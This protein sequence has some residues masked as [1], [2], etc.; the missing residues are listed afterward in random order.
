MP[1]F[2]ILH[3]FKHPP[4][5]APPLILIHLKHSKTHF[6]FNSQIFIEPMPP[7]LFHN[8]AIFDLNEMLTKLG[9]KR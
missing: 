3:T 9:K 2:Q 8:L 4:T 7:T 6:F 5:P 1:Y